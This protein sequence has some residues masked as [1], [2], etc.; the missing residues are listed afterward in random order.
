ML[1]R[2]R[3]CI[4]WPVGGDTSYKSTPAGQ[5]GWG[6]APG[7]LFSAGRV[8]GRV[9]D[10]G[11]VFDIGDKY[12]GAPGGSGKLYLRISSSPWNNESTG[13]YKVKVVVK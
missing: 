1:E 10:N 13:E 7:E 2:E 6:K 11:K 12:E 5:P 9:G 4:G 3:T 8:V